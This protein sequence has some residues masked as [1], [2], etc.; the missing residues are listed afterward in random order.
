MLVATAQVFYIILSP[1]QR[2]RSPRGQ[3]GCM[4]SCEPDSGAA[5]EL[6]PVVS[7]VMVLQLR[8]GAGA[9]GCAVV[10]KL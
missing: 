1:K 4:K 10:A 7:G 9:P 8:Q 3:H 2:M 5:A 6:K